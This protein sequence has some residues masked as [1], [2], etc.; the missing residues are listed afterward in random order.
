[1]EGLHAGGSH[2][3]L[4]VDAS[5]LSRVSDVCETVRQRIPSVDYLV[6]S[7]GVA[8]FDGRN[9]TAE[10]LDYK[11]NSYGVNSIRVYA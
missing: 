10:G 8:T 3:F 2:S 4:S 7:Q 6:L 9:E 11:V 1:M 5:L